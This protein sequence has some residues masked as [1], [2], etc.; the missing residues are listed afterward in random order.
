MFVVWDLARRCERLLPDGIAR[1]SRGVHHS[2]IACIGAMAHI[3]QTGCQTR[4][5]GVYTIDL[6]AGQSPWTKYTLAT[7]R[8][9][10]LTLEIKSEVMFERNA[11]AKRFPKVTQK[12]QSIFR[13]EFAQ[14]ISIFR[15]KESFKRVAIGCLV[16][17]FQQ[18]S[19]IASSKLTCA[20]VVVTMIAKDW[21]SSTMR[22]SYSSR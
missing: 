13:R 6:A 10:E 22:Q 2:N 15:T 7:P 5:R 21:Q 4:A 14:Y 19:G 1:R 18:W 20:P 9:L 17:F 8:I 12:T 3:A 11:F 16:M